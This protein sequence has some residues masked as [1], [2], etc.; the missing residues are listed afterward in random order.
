MGNTLVVEPPGNEWSVAAGTFRAR[1]G[2]ADG[3]L[4]RGSAR[5]N[6]LAC[7]I[8]PTSSGRNATRGVPAATRR[9]RPQASIDLHAR[10]TP[11]RSPAEGSVVGS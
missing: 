8:G 6:P 11:S 4:S 1:R 5:G 9:A 3:A 10:D 7:N 2:R